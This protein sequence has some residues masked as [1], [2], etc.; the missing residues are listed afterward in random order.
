MTLN[1]SFATFFS[2]KLTCRIPLS[3]APRAHPS[4]KGLWWT[5]GSC[6]GEASLPGLRINAKHA[7]TRIY[8]RGFGNL[9]SSGAYINSL[10]PFCAAKNRV[11]AV[12][13]LPIGINYVG[14]C[15]A[16]RKLYETGLGDFKMFLK[17]QEKGIFLKLS[18]RS[19]LV[20]QRSPW[21]LCKYVSDSGNSNVTPWFSFDKHY[22]KKGSD[23]SA[24]F[25]SYQ[26]RNA[27]RELHDM[28]VGS[29]YEK[30]KAR[31]APEKR[32]RDDPDEKKKRTEVEEDDE[33]LLKA[34]GR[35]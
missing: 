16:N 32:S 23:I 35:S 25:H 4:Q 18:N 28:K 31:E 17:G 19:K 9:C 26:M 13:D 29:W 33:K 22:L 10:E 6:R 21:N 12:I 30:K 27:M 24:F 2:N 8:V 14:Q 7:G 5:E 1:L 3:S 20:G 15:G 34:S 11:N